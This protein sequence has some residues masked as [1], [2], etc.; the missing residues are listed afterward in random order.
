MAC[1]I[2]TK[3]KVNNLE[4]LKE[5]IIKLN[6]TFI[7]KQK[8]HDIYYKAP[9]QINDLSVIRLRCLENGKGIFTIKKD[10]P[11]TE[12]NIKIKEEIQTE[13]LSADIFKTILKELGYKEIFVKEKI[14]EEYKYSNSLICV[15]VLPFIGNYIE[16]EAEKEDIEKTAESL[17][18][19][20]TDAIKQTYMDIFNDYK[21]E[22]NK[23]D[24]N[25]I[26]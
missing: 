2:E 8:E 24:I 15:D 7:V 13:V 25:M 26:F 20:M 18:L 4:E 14:R 9:Q 3:F 21:K 1:E 12:E 22:N 17:G 23:P 5:K 11:N 16:I 6:A 19:N 10:I